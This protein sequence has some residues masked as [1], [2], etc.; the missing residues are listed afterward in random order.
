MTINTRELTLGKPDAQSRTVP[1]VLSTETPVDRGDYVE[2]LDHSS[3]ASIDL[4]RAPLPLIESHDTRNLPI[5][6]V[7]NLR[8]EGRKLRG[9][10]RF[11]NSPRGQAAFDDVQ[12]GILRSVSVGYEYVGNPTP[13][14]DRAL[15]FKFRPLE[16]SAVSVPADPA[17]GF[18]RSHPAMNTTQQD[19]TPETLTRSQRR[20]L[21]EEAEEQRSAAELERARILEI[22]ALC[23]LHK[24]PHSAQR[25]MVERGLSIPEARGI[26]L[27]HILKQGERQ[28]ASSYAAGDPWFTEQRDSGSY[29]IARAILAA[30]GNDWSKAGFEREVSREI[31]RRTGRDTTGVFV[32]VEAMIPRRRDYNTLTGAAGGALVATNLQASAFIEVLRA[33]SRVMQLGATIMSG[34]VGNVDIPR[35]TAAAPAQWI[36]EGQALTQAQGTFDTIS[37]RPKTLGSFTTL[38]RN[39]LMQGTP[40]AEQLIRADMAAVL[41]L[42]IDRAAILGTG[43]GGQPQGLLNMAGVGSVVGGTNGAAVT[44]DHLIRLAGVV[45][46]ASADGGNMGYLTNPQVLTALLQTKATTGQY[47]APIGAAAGEFAAPAGGAYAPG[48]DRPMFSALG[49]PLATTANVPGNLTKGTGTNLSAVLFGNWSDLMIGEWGVLEILPNPYANGAYEAGAIQVRAL[50][51]IDIAVRHAES[52]AVMRDAITG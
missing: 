2:I 6:I 43:T 24:V 29:S 12:S 27:E 11:S 22:E 14:G 21:R 26:V 49:Y 42:E 30:A 9:L 3:P 46:A 16:V 39:L 7:D 5:G 52:F 34:L 51:T 31:A 47:L 13:Q 48:A 32:P 19:T 35:R 25:D 8:L 36:T 4:S 15:L 1:V 10:A 23:A 33:K 41:A 20:A 45:A 17:A 44:F 18:N 28:A 38:S 37:L 50:Q 40:D